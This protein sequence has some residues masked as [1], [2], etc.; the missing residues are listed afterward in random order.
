[1]RLD[2]HK[3]LSQEELHAPI[4]HHMVPVATSFHEEMTIE[5]LLVI[6]RKRTIPHD[7]RYFYSVDDDHRLTGTVSTHD[8][9]LADPATKFG[10]IVD[11]EVVS[12]QH[13]ASVED[14]LKMLEAHGIQALPVIDS[15]KHLKGLFELVPHVSDNLRESKR[16]T[17]KDIFQFIGFSLALG[18]VNSSILEYRYRMPWLLCNILAGLICASIAAAFAGILTKYVVLAMFI[19]LILSLGESV[20]MQSMSLSLQFLHYGKLHYKH[21]FRR[22]MVEGKTAVL[23]GATC[24]ILV[25]SVFWVWHTT[26]HAMLAVTFSIFLTMLFST[27]F[28]SLIPIVLHR[29][30]LD[31]RVASGP[32]VLM[33]ADVTVTI[34]YLSLSS[35]MLT[36]FVT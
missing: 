1:M 22:F 23:L 10:E 27:C 5:E 21:L 13:T 3:G 4:Q 2:I 24:A 33:L 7:I 15:E 9:L 31:P 17:S 26:F 35:W 19:P 34:I 18:R 6:L 16:Y 25:G 14:G 12:I 20:S 36:T 8:L 29:F 32:L 28:G 30:S 11:H